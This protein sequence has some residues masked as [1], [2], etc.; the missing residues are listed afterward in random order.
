MWEDRL[1]GREFFEDFFAK[2]TAR[3][4]FMDR[5]SVMFSIFFNYFV[6]T[7][8]NHAIPFKVVSGGPCQHTTIFTGTT[9][10]FELV[11]YGKP[12][13]VVRTIKWVGL[14]CDPSP[15]VTT[16]SIRLVRV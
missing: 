10:I 13:S 8:E 5:A 1:F 14:R 6:A 11:I 2:S 9:I 7:H 4:L 15:E 3:H 12:L 16:D